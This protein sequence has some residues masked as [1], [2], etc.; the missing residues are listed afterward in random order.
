VATPVVALD[1]MG[2]DFAPQ[3]EV[4]A[5]VEA[6]R[7]WPVRI[8]L[9]GQRDRLE[10]LLREYGGERL[11][12]EIVHADEVI[13]MDEMPLMAIRRKRRSSIVIAS[14]LLKE[15]V[16]HA[17]VS[18]GNTGAI[19]A[20]MKFIV[21]TLPGVERPALAVVLPN[22][23]G[24][25]VLI[26]AGANVNC[27]PFHLKQFAIMGATY[28]QMILKIPNPRVGVLSIG[29][30]DIKGNATVR[31]L[32]EMMRTAPVRF[33]G[34]VEGK[35]IFT[36]YADVIVCDGFI[37]NV[38]LK[39][40]ESL[41]DM[42]GYLLKQEIRRRPLAQI[43]YLLMKPAMRAFRR[44]VD[45]SE[46]GGAPLL[47]IRGLAIICHGRSTP[48][49]IRNAIRVAHDFVVA[50]L[51]QLIQARIAEDIQAAQAQEKQTHG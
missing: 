27:R 11:A 7:S 35:D 15:G 8:L 41:A 24:Y 26:D 10:P 45:Y 51:D 19:M 14:H 5:A 31:R 3:I 37:G 38:V 1:A 30:E 32:H 13:G 50:E 20:A 46:Y 33:I 22:R 16:C 42:I 49:A 2:G 9:V 25:C 17:V 43:G 18:A 47:G 40:S 21:G 4:R 36:G 6:A 48:K 12:I 28:A 29:E 23:R 44:R 34:N 39:A